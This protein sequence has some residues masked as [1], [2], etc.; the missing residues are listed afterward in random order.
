MKNVSRLLASLFV[1]VTA[2]PSAANAAGVAP[3][4]TYTDVVWSVS[5]SV[6]EFAGCNELRIDATGD[7]NNSSRLSVY[8]S[9]N[10]VA[11]YTSYPV[12]G[13]AGFLSNGTFTMTLF[14]SSGTV[15]ACNNLNGLSGTCRYVTSGTNAPLGTAL[16]TFR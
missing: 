9:L 8:G 3:T 11:S 2:L 1:L 7:L 6:P 13:S 15:L 12:T 5:T 16:L 4:N 10:C 14:V